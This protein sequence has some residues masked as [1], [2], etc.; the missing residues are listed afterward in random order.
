MA[1]VGGVAGLVSLCV[2]L[3]LGVVAAKSDG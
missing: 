3:L 1:L 2:S